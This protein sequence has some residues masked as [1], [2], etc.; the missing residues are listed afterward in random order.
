MDK[1]KSSRYFD[2]FISKVL[3]QVSNEYSIT[4]NAKQQLNSVLCYITRDICNS[5]FN[6]VM[7]SKK[8]TISVKEIINTIQILFPGDLAENSI[9]EG[10]KAIQPRTGC[11]YNTRQVNANIIFPVALLEKFLHNFGYWNIMVTAQSPIFLAAVIEYICAEILDTGVLYTKERNHMRVSIRDLEL[12]IRNDTELNALFQKFNMEFIG[13]GIIPFIHP[14]LDVIKHTPVY[15]DITKYQ[16]MSNKCLLSKFTFEK[17]V[18][19]IVHKHKANMKISKNVSV[20]IQFYIEHFIINLLQY[21]NLA[22]IHAYRTKLQ[23]IDIDLALNISG[24]VNITTLFQ[25]NDNIFTEPDTDIDMYNTEYTIE[26]H[27]FI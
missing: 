7:M 22:C 17:I 27:H 10:K 20:I 21:A 11:R 5:V 16:N 23:N 24:S 4:L 15:K 3:K 18:R 8:R 25:N 1:T 2:T 12:T 14:H 9:C 6:M 13:G 26:Q 19:E